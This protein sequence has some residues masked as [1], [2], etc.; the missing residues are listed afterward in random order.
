[1]E[2]QQYLELPDVEFEII[3]SRNEEIKELESEMTLL[4]EIFRDLSLI[5]H[6]Q[7]DQ[8]DVS[9]MNVEHASENIE[10]AERHLEEAAVIQTKVQSFYWK[11]A[12]VFGGV[13][14]GGV[15]LAFFVPIAG[16]VT[17]GVAATGALSFIGLALKR[18]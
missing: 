12:L 3:R 2:D 11:G 18:K 5:V 17:S 16:I 14:L 4:A 10:I 8:I 6:E 13:A 15:G 1:M 7:G 9:A